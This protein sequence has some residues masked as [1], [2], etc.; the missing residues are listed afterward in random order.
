MDALSPSSALNSTSGV[1]DELTLYF[2]NGPQ[3]VDHV[4]LQEDQSKGEN[5]YLFVVEALDSFTGDWLIIIWNGTSIGHKKIF[6]VTPVQVDA[7]RFVNL[8]SAK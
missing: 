6:E 3:F 5:V 2:S 4:M 8:L 7:I 1:N